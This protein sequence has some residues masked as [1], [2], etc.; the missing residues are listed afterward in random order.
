MRHIKLTEELKQKA[1]KEF[2]EKLANERFSDDKI[3]FTFN[4]KDTT[5]LVDNDK[6]VVNIKP[7]AWL[8]MWALVSS[9]SGEIGW[10]GLVTRYSDKIFEITDI[11][12]YP[13][14]VTGVTVQ[15]DDVGYGNWLHK[16]LSD[17]Q[18]NSLR[19]HGH[20]HVNMGVSPSGVD[21][22]WYN[23]ILQGLFNDDYYIF[24]ILNKRDDIFIEIYDLATNTIYEKKDIIINVLISDTESLQNWVTTEKAR[25]LQQKTYTQQSI[26]FDTNSRLDGYKRLEDI[27]PFDA[28]EDEKVNFRDFVLNLTASDLKDAEL[29]QTIMAEINRQAP[30]TSY[31][32][33]GWLRWHEMSDADK[34]DLA[35]DYYLFTKPNNAAS[36]KTKQK[37]YEATKKKQRGRPKKNTFS[38]E[39]YYDQYN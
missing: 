23:E 17:E 11:L 31:F 22:A 8:K 39:D 7:E 30:Y 25:A 12:V 38:W 20:S 3:N 9:E 26:G 28:E 21:T 33:T 10:H 24:A 34:L 1:L 18:I 19:F 29:K 37:K 32:G 36:V 27:K 14:F 35:Q 6:V 4:L 16:E 5:E 2:Q 15:T 13:Q